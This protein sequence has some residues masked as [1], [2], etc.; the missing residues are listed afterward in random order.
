MF[1]IVFNSDENYIKYSAVLMT[2]I[3]KNTNVKLGFKD[4]FNKA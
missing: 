4:Y 1:H 3:V 2:S